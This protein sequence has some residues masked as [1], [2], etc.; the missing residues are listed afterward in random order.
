MK[1][2]LRSDGVGGGHDTMAAGRIQLPDVTEATYLRIVSELWQRF[3]VALGERAGDG[4]RMVGS[5]RMPLRVP[6]GATD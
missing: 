2:V 6:R 1:T 3:L 5:S 4:R